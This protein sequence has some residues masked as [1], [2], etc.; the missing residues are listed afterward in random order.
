MWI[1]I[2]VAVVFLLILW[3]VMAYNKLV[4]GQNRVEEAFPTMDVY[5]KKRYDLFLNLVGTVKGYKKY[6]NE[7]L[8]HAV[9]ARTMAGM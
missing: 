1:W 4:R 5:L 6:V 9:S 8:T 3:A 7:W 2:L